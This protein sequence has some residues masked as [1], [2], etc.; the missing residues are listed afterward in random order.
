M[1]LS[2]ITPNNIKAFVE[3]YTKLIYNELVGLPF[4]IQE[5]ILYRQSKCQSCITVGHVEEGPGH[6][7][8][9]GC[10]IP[11]KWYV[12]KSCNN[13]TKFPDLMDKNNWNKFKVENDITL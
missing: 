13:G 12:T 3:G 8:H 6:C 2:Q 4:H 7:E 11:G 9:C 5:Q 1:K 10:S